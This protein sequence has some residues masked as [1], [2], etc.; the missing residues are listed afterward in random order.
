MPTDEKEQDRLDLH[1]EIMLGLLGGSI[2]L[3]PVEKPHHILDVGTGTG[4]WAI[5]AADKFPSAEVIGTDLSPIQPRWVPPNCQFQVDDAE[6]DWTFKNDYFDYIH[7]RNLAQSISKWDKVMGEIFRCTEPGGFVELAELGVILPSPPPSRPS[8]ERLTILPG[9]G[10]IFCDDDTMTKDNAFRRIV[11]QLNQ[12][13]LPSIGR[14]AATAD[15]IVARLK[16]AGFVDVHVTTKKHPFGP[17]PR[18][19]RLKHIGAM[20]LMMSETGVEAYALAGLTRILGMDAADATKLCDDAVA[21]V[22]NKNTHMYSYLWVPPPFPALPLRCCGRRELLTDKPAMSHM[23]ASLTGIT[24]GA[25]NSRMWGVHTCWWE[26]S[27]LIGVALSFSFAARVANNDKRYHVFFFARLGNTVRNPSNP[28]LPRRSQ[29]TRNHLSRYQDKSTPQ[30]QTATRLPQ[31][32]RPK[33]K[34]TTRD[35]KPAV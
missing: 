4:I 25:A 28:P 9:Q 26:G 10:E 27:N 34:P 13:A 23:A 18:D 17:W 31:A 11:Y 12:V 22:K 19:R 3:A 30:K 1:H 21:A 5:D 16:N 24:S 14:P 8:S 33:R 32:K 2:N 6:L 20:A 35:P 7:V 29:T 15:L